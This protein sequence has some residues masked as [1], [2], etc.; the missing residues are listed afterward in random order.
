MHVSWESATSLSISYRPSVDTWP[1]TPS[2]LGVFYIYS[3]VSR[4]IGRQ[5]TFSRATL[6]RYV[7]AQSIV[8]QPILQ[9]EVGLWPDVS[10][11]NQA[12]LHQVHKSNWGQAL[13][14]GRFLTNWTNWVRLSEYVSRTEDSFLSDDSL[15]KPRSVAWNNL[16]ILTNDILTDISHHIDI[17]TDTSY[18]I[19]STDISTN[20]LA[21]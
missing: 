8:G 20:L 9:T 21:K 7:D 10:C 2:W 1:K 16:L 5:S 11:S 15:L 3:T 4:Y 14:R 6:G 13:T 17:S 19:I 12:W 18:P